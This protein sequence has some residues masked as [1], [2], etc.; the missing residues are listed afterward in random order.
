MSAPAIPGSEKFQSVAKQAGELVIDPRL[1]L[2]EAP[3]DVEVGPVTYAVVSHKLTQINDESA[4]TISKV[5]GSL[6]AAE[7]ADFNTALGDARGDLFEL[8][9]Y[10]SVHGTVVQ[11]LIQWT[12]ENRSTNPGIRDGDAFLV[13]DPWVGSAHQSDAAIV[14]PIFVDGKLFGWTGATL[15][16]LDLGGRFPGSMIP[17][18]ED[19]FSESVPIPPVK[20]LENGEIRADIEDMFL[21]RSRMPQSAALDLRA[22]LA[23]TSVATERV[24]DLTRH[25]GADVVAAVIRETLDTTETRFRGRLAELPDGT[26]RHHYL[27]DSAGVGD[28]GVYHLPVTMHK[29]GDRL[30]FDLEDVD[31]QVGAINCGRSLAEAG[32]MSAVL[33]LLC[34]DLPWAP[35][36]ML[37]AVEFRFKPGT[38]LAAEFPAAAGGGTCQAA[39]SSVNSAT[40]VVSKMLAAS[41]EYRRN[42]LAVSTPGWVFQMIG[43]TNKTGLPTLALSLDPCAGG[44]GARSWADGDDTAGMMLGPSTEIPNIESQEW[45]EPL[46][47]LYRSEAP[48]TG[49]PGKFR[50][51]NGGRS[52]LVPHDTPGDL[53]NVNYASGTA[54]PGG[55]GLCGGWPSRSGYYKIA[56]E[57]TVWKQYGE[58]TVPAGEDDVDVEIEWPPSQGGITPIGLNDVFANGWLGGGGFGDPLERDLAAVQRDLDEGSVTAAHAGA[59]YGVVLDGEQIDREATEQRR[60]ELRGR[61]LGRGPLPQ[62]PEPVLPGGS[63][64]LDEN[65]VVSAAGETSCGRCRTGLAAAGGNYKLG[66]RAIET[67]LGTTE[68]VWVDPTTYV[69]EDTLVFREFV[70]PGCGTLLET[71]VSLSALPPLHDKQLD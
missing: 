67:P 31:P 59:V 23:A 65:L 43:G 34:P 58:G 68:R 71:E 52:A 2:Y 9:S 48:D 54:I 25:Y 8:G 50:G 70:C 24:Q 16:F 22:L 69:D 26:W 13:N 57:S 66:C 6:A 62:A 44:I 38:I 53:F 56:R 42:L 11:R 41:P 51:G 21:R 18:A 36:A 63:R 14:R 32:I 35:G 7:A 29:R 4:V 49:G 12:L 64:W 10:I 45:Y 19:V 37:R 5:S 17:D 60:A 61:R 15:H 33:P 3:D 55:A 28:R 1:P 20:I 30:V 40:V 47:W 27:W 39:W 46:L